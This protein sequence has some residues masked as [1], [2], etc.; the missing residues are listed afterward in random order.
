MSVLKVRNLV[1]GEGIPKICVPIVGQ[2]KDEIIQAAR[3]ICTVPADLVEWRADWFEHVLELDAV[4]EVL[5]ELRSVLAD[6]PV[7]FTFR[8]KAEGG[9]REIPFETYSEL[10]LCVSKTGQVDMV[11]VEVYIDEQSLRVEQ[12]VQC[13]QQAGVKVIGSNHDFKKTPTKEEIIRR[14]CHM[15]T[16]GVDI[17]KIAVMPQNKKDVLTLLAATEEMVSLHADRPIITMSMT[18]MGVIS[19]I[20]GET[21][22]SAV[23]FATA[24]K[25]SAPGQMEA[26]VLKDILKMMSCSCQE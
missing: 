17:P 25:A 2:T 10:V 5:T 19:R 3:N 13:L 12:L 14:L 21:F 4:K 11:D 24:G 9:E 22:G 6:M 26:N 20:A 15:Q 8:T 7:L 18:K 16:I 23:T 1:I